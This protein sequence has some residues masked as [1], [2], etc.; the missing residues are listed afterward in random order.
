MV[1]KIYL[2][3][4]K[5]S[6]ILEIKDLK[7]YYT[8]RKSLF[9]TLDVKAVDGVT[10]NISQGETVAIVGESG[11]GKTTLGRTV[12]KLVKSSGGTISFQGSDITKDPR[13]EKEFRKKAQII[14]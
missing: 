1:L 13:D 6:K 8:V 4:K 10:L 14:F 2:L 11:S 9:R 3:V 12:L 5:M 7:T